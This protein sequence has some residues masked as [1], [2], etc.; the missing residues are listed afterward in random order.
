MRY[1][2]KYNYWFNLRQFQK[3]Q[4]GCGKRRRKAATQEFG[5]ILVG[6]RNKY[7][8]SGRKYNFRLLGLCNNFAYVVMLSAAKDI[9]EKDAKHIEK[10]CRVGLIWRRLPAL[11]LLAK[12]KRI[13]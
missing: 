11:C 10:P 6:F 3:F 1:F 4:N 7:S 2:S 5:G 9:L 8:E 13:F 12:Y